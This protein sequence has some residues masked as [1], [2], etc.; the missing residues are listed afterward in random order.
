MDDQQ[1]QSVTRI[2]Y[3]AH[4][5][6]RDHVGSSTLVIANSENDVK[7]IRGKERVRRRGMSKRRRKD[8]PEEYYA[9]S[10]NTQSHLYSSAV[11]VDQEHLYHVDNEIDPQNLCLPANAGDALSSMTYGVDGARDYDPTDEVD[12]SEYHHAAE[13]ADEDQLSHVSEES[14][15][16]PHAAVGVVQQSSLENSED[17]TRQTDYSVTA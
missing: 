15:R 11:N 6:L 2:R 12:E 4:E 1:I 3:V 9:A 5:C 7:R 16:D 8:D 13:E 14:P 17:V 10:I